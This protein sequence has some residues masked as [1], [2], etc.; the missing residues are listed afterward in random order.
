MNARPLS[1]WMPKVR[2]YSGVTMLKPAPGLWA[3]SAAGFDTM[4]KGIPK[5]FP[6]TGMPVE[7][8]ADSTPGRAWILSRSWS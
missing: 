2:K 4:S 1:I 5:P 8:D 3:G 6:R 7:T